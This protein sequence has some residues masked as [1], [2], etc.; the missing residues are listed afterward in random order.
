M[1][2]AGDAESEEGARAVDAPARSVSPA[3]Y[4]PL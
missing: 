2:D 1:I 3:D 4:S